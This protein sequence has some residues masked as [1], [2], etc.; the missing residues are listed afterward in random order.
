MIVSPASLTV[1][2]VL[3]SA[4]WFAGMTTVPPTM[5]GVPTM[6][7]A[8]AS[9]RSLVPASLVAVT[10]QLYVLP[11]SRPDHDDRR[12][13][14]AGAGALGAAVARDAVGVVLSDSAAVLGGRFEGDRDAAVVGHDGGLGRRVGRD[15]GNHDCVGVVRR[16]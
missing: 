9:E 11:L 7:S 4:P 12:G 6:T 1:S 14:G 16:R 13:V 15:R 3:T 10:V 2:P 8:D 5:V